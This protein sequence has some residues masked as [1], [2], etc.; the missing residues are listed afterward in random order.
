MAHILNDSCFP[1][2]WYWKYIFLKYVFILLYKYNV[3][4]IYMDDNLI[5]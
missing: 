4:L 5:E 2:M 1:P 3:T